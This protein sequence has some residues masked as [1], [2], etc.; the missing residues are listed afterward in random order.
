MV[1]LPNI[2][3]NDCSSCDASR[4]ERMQHADRRAEE[5]ARNISVA[6]QLA[7]QRDNEAIWA[8]MSQLRN[9]RR[10][11]LAEMTPE[12]QTDADRAHIQ[13]QWQQLLVQQ[14]QRPQ[15]QQTS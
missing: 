10:Q 13:Q 11:R 6:Q 2:D 12:Q 3:I 15:Q 14:P 9:E 8:R 4:I 1:L 7:I 5:F